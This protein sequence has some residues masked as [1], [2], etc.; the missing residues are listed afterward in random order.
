MN[1]SIDPRI[2]NHFPLNLIFIRKE[3]HINERDGYTR[4]D[5]TLAVSCHVMQIS[6][7]LHVSI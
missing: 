2:S 7:Y 5:L 4:D 6:V 3:M 1:Y